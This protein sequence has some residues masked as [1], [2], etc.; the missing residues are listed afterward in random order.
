M[1]DQLFPVVGRVNVD[2]DHTRVRRDLQQ[3][4]ARVAW[5]RVALH[6]DL[7]AQ[8]SG[9]GFDG[10]DQCQVVLQLGQGGHEDVEH[11]G[12][13]ALL[14]C[15]GFG[16]GAIGSARVAH[17]HAQGC[18]HH[19]RVGLKFRG[20]LGSRCRWRGLLGG[21]ARLQGHRGSRQ[22]VARRKRV[23]LDHV[24][25]LGRCRPRQGVQWQAPSHGRVARHQVHA[26]VAQEPA[27]GFP[28]AGLRVVGVDRLQRQDIAHRLVQPLAED[29]AQADPFHLVVQTGVKRVHVHGQAA[30]TPEVIPGVF[31]AGQ[32][33]VIRQA[34]LCGQ[35]L[36]EA[37]GVVRGAVAGFA[38]VS[39][40]GGV[41]P[42]R[43]AIGAPINAECPA[44]QLFA[45][46]PLALAKVQKT[47]LTVLL[48][49]LVH[50]FGGQAPLGWAQG[51]GVPFG[52]I[53]VL[54]GHKGGLAP[55]GQSH[56]LRHQ[57]RIDLFAQCQHI[58]P[59]LVA[60]GLCHTG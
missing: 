11:T 36:H 1:I 3:L 4:E 28:G 29:A 25:A 20:R 49:Q 60:V 14:L 48:A 56:V 18:A 24:P 59:L 2:L 42:T 57:L 58:G 39:K 21:R 53:S 44:R 22:C 55:H 40:N 52:A 47:T 46:V 30:F 19:S 9:G 41:L 12:C 43:R 32:H 16:H 5:R 27:P 50:Q 31:V 26:F 45:R 37:Q 10:A 15:L 17:F 33:R 7:H 51:V 34:Q 23:L 54:R 35:F 38:L 6:D 8:C 13:W